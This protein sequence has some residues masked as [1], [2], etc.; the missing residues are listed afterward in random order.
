MALSCN[1]LGQVVHTPICRQAVQFGIGQEAV[2]PY[3]WEGMHPRLQWLIHPQAHGLREG[4]E[5]PAYSSWGA[6][7]KLKIKQSN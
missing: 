3:S 1:N 2:M 5:H 4:D 7:Y 6:H